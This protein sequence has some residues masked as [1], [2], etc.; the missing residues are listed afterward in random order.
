VLHNQIFDNGVTRLQFKGTYVYNREPEYF[1]QLL[2]FNFKDEESAWSTYLG[3]DYP[4]APLATGAMYNLNDARE[5]VS[6]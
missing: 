2:V 1:E 6:D 5:I 4:N 3:E